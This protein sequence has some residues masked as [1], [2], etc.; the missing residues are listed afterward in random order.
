MNGTKRKT[1]KRIGKNPI[2]M[3]SKA[4]LTPTK[5]V[6]LTIAKTIVSIKN[7]EKFSKTS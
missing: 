2:G 3:T 7:L 6:I 4:V 5:V 1:P